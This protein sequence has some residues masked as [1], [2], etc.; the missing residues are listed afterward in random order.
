MEINSSIEYSVEEA[1]TA[2]D[3]VQEQ[4]D[5]LSKNMSQVI[6]ASRQFGE[7]L[8]DESK[9]WIVSYK[10]FDKLLKPTKEEKAAEEEA[11]KEKAAK[12][13]RDRIRDDLANGYR[14]QTRKYSGGEKKIA[15]EIWKELYGEEM[16]KEKFD[17]LFSKKKTSST[18]SDEETVED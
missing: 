12:A 17:E 4:Y 3:I 6:E 18:S 13:I 9:N 15:K 10:E 2:A 1:R 14:F 11:A 16:S 7:Y 8:R 5:N